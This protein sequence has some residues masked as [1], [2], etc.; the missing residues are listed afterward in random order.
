M[1][2]RTS[3]LEAQAA[4]RPAPAERPRTPTELARPSFLLNFP[5]SFST[6]VAN[7]AWMRDMP[8]SERAPDLRRAMTQFLEL[9]RVLASEALVYLLHL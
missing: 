7:N 6:E 4:P 1:S 9:Y 2:I 3:V 8:E 5:F